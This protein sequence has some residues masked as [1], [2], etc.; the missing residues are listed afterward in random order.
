M[1]AIL[2]A[3]TVEAHEVLSIRLPRGLAAGLWAVQEGRPL[4]D[5]SYGQYF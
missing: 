2:E 1:S 5:V 3:P 4:Q